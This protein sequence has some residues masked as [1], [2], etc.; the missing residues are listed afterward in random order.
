MYPDVEKILRG[1]NLALF[2]AL[3]K[4]LGYADVELFSDLVAGFPTIGR[5]SKTG[6]W[7]EKERQPTS[8]ARTLMATAKWA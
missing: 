8:D 1:K 5:S 3:L 6:I 2:Q 4:D 7:P